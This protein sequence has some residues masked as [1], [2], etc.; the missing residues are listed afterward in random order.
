MKYLF[1]ILLLIT[2]LTLVLDEKIPLMNNYIYSCS[3]FIRQP[4][5]PAENNQDVVIKCIS[6]DIESK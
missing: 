3:N 1:V 6:I 2:T 4:I 5:C